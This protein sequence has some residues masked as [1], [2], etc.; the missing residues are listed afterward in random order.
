MS[1]LRGRTRDSS[2]QWLIIGVVLGF[3]CSGVFCLG[4]YAIGSL[5][6][7]APGTSDTAL[8]PT[9]VIIVTTTPPPE[10]PTEAVVATSAPPPASTQSAGGAN[11]VPTATQMFILPTEVNATLAQA[12]TQQAV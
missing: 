5:R 10:T 11:G 2:W 4:L 8:Q 3:G 12:P 1:S 9:T 7:S 6:L